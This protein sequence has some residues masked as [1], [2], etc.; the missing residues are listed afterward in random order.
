MNTYGYVLG[1][2]VSHVDPLGLAVKCKTVLK[3]PGFDVQTCNEDGTSPSEQDAKDA[4]R[5]TDKELDKA[6]KNNNYKNAHELKDDLG[7]NSKSDIF[8]D[9]NGNMY[10]GPRQGTGIPQYLHMNIEGWVPPK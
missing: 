9:K 10:S 6:C 7:L 1:N 4:K 8:V 5:M 2:P 3:L